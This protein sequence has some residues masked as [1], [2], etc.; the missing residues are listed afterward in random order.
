MKERALS[1]W[2]CRKCSP[3]SCWQVLYWSQWFGRRWVLTGIFPSDSYYWQPLSNRTTW[4]CCLKALQWCGHGEAAP[5]LIVEKAR[6]KRGMWKMDQLEGGIVHLGVLERTNTIII[7]VLTDLTHWTLAELTL[8]SIYIW[9]DRHPSDC[10]RPNQY[11]NKGVNYAP[12]Q[13]EIAVHPSL[14]WN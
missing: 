11:S 8:T 10:W 3:C 9:P 1:K 12:R 7:S 4:C 14:A 6:L 13:R 5:L 2:L